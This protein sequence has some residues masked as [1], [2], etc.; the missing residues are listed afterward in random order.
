MVLEL[1]INPK[2]ISGKPWEM[3]FVGFV[4]SFIAA[5]LA[6]WI[7]KNYVSTIMITITIIASIP[8]VRSV[9]KQE[10]EKDVVI[11][12]EGRLLKEHSKAIMLL[13][14]LFLGFV[15]SFTLLYVFMPSVIVEKMFSAQLETIIT[16]QAPTGNFI[17]SLGITSKIF[18]NNIKILL[19]CVIFSFFYGAGAIFILT[20]N[21]SVMATAIGAFIRNNLFYAKGIFDYFQVTTIGLLQ[22]TLH[23]IP[24]IAAYFVAALGSSMI[25]FALMK[26]DFMDKNFKRV[27]RDII[28][29]MVV[30]V[31]ILIISAI[32]EVYITPLIL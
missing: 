7:F 19:F 29:L 31:I 30:A 16:V 32:I 18:F 1:L 24:E 12:Q 22:Y 10:E 21:A 26:H 8:V 25:S 11:K 14:Y 3:F 9:I 15:F 5:F 2:K 6:L 23:G 17:S 28:N 20:W 4:Y 27:L 13:V